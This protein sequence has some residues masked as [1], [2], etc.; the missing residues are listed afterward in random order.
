[1]VTDVSEEKLS[2]ALNCGVDYAVDILKRRLS[3]VIKEKFGED[4]LMWC[5]VYSKSRSLEQML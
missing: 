5:M 3:K 2:M 4:G 1:M